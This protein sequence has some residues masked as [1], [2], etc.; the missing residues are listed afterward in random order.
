MLERLADLHAQIAKRQKNE[1]NREA[2]LEQ[3]AQEYQNVMAGLYRRRRE[4]RSEIDELLS[5]DQEP[6]LTTAGGPRPTPLLPSK[7]KKPDPGPK[8]VDLLRRPGQD[9]EARR[10]DEL[11]E[12]VTWAQGDGAGDLLKQLEDMYRDSS[13]TLVDM[14]A[15][16]PLP[17]WAT[18]IRAERGNLQLRKQRLEGWE[19]ALAERLAR[20][21]QAQERF[22]NDPRYLY[23]QEWK[24]GAYAWHA[25]LDREKERLQA[26][27]N[28]LRAE[29]QRLEREQDR[30]DK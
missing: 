8:I 30:T 18:E 9:D 2:E 14:L 3:A 29:L 7:P 1:A 12:F 17:L 22:K 24:R 25:F 13:K 6:H 10:K 15:I 28:D 4:V 11:I 23:W 19:A 27:I 5:R 26:Q 20:F 21:E 16:V